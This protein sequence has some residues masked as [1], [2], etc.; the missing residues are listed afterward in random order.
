MNNGLKI[1]DAF[2]LPLFDEI[3]GV[4]ETD[5]SIQIN[6][7]GKGHHK[8]LMLSD[9]KTHDYFSD[10]EKQLLSGIL[11]KGLKK[12]FDDIWLINTE[13]DK[14]SFEEILNQLKPQTV[15]I[16][17][18]DAFMMENKIKMENHHQAL[19][20]GIGILK[21]QSLSEYINDNAAKG[22]LWI[23]MKKMFFS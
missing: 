13:K 6:P 10:P 5:F 1:D 2:V 11:D 22:K 15:I 20:H 3:I 17:G 12:T 4:K 16:W 21:A 14:L 7:L 19:L 23:A 9:C 18:C 8:L